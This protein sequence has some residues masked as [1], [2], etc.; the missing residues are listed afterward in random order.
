MKTK[1]KCGQRLFVGLVIS[2]LSMSCFGLQVRNSDLD[3]KKKNEPSG[4]LK[5]TFKG[6]LG[7]KYPHLLINLTQNLPKV[8]RRW[9]LIYSEDWDN[10][11]SLEGKIKG[12]DILIPIKQG[13]YFASITNEELFG[14]N[15]FFIFPLLFREDKFIGTSFGFDE[16][17]DSNR[18]SM[19]SLKSSQCN[20]SKQ[21]RTVFLWWLVSGDVVFNHCPKLR[22]DPNKITE[23]VIT[24][25]DE[26]L[27]GW[28]SFFGVI[29]G[30]LAGLPLFGTL[31]YK[32]D[33]TVEIKYPDHP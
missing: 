11:Y 28:R 13:E 6:D 10:I 33:S 1:M 23:V 29:P 4:Y 31:V 24:F 8:K 5:V 9:P 3:I 12:R 14:S 17:Y 30:I 32:S 22:I 27:K 26:Q 21:E 18:Y 20:N 25:S 19:N 7:Y 15:A 2:V 16:K